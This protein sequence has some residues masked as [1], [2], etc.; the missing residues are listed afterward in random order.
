MV[1]DFSHL[2]R[3]TNNPFIEFFNGSFRDEYLYKNWFLSLQDARAIID[4]WRRD[5]NSYRPHSSLQDR[6]PDQM[7]LKVLNY[8]V[9][10]NLAVSK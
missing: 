10:S 5:Y 7:E 4:S 1:L 3:P 6:T 8:R 2:G 9:N